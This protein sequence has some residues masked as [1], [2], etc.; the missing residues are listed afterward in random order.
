MS[1]SERAALSQHLAQCEDCRSYQLALPEVAAAI[2]AEADSV[3]LPDV[4][5]EWSTLQSRLNSPARS[6]T[7]KRRLS[8]PVL[9]LG[10]PLAAAAGLAFLF[11]NPSQETTV[12]ETA[13]SD[14]TMVTHVDYVK[15]GDPNA[16]T[17]VYVDQDSGWLVVWATNSS[18]SRNG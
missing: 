4:A 16:S 11:I 5:A 7:G 9:W 6:S 18:H 13:L 8:A 3:S 12:K 1:E 17:M 2:R 15:S 14:D 10:A